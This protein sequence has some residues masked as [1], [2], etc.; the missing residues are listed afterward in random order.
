LYFAFSYVWSL[1]F[2]VK[3]LLYIFLIIGENESAPHFCM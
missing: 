3:V 1:T 2:G